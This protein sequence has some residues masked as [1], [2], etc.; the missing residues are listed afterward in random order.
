MN[1]ASSGEQCADV[2][3]RVREAHV[4]QL[5]QEDANGRSE[6]KTPDK[7]HHPHL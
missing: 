2:L 7:A 5:L 6:R 3:R 4:V 1:V